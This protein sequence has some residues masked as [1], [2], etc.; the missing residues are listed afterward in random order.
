MNPLVVG[1]GLVLLLQVHAHLL[2]HACQAL[3]GGLLDVGGVRGPGGR[4]AAAGAP[5]D[6]DIVEAGVPGVAVGG[7][8]RLGRQPHDQRGAARPRAARG[9]TE[10]VDGMQHPE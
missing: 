8:R 3:R 9:D 1:L 6:A 5:V 10:S 4:A 2:L 7:L